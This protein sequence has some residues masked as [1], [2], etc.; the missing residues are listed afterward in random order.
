MTP[1][2][3]GLPSNYRFADLTLDVARRCVTRQDRTIELKA[4]DFDLLRF[5][6]EQAPNVVNPDVLAEKVWGRHFV[7]PENVAQR[8]MLLRQSLSD[9]ANKPRY[10]ETVRNKGYRLIPV[11]ELAPAETRRATPWPRRLVTAAAALL[12]AVAAGY[13]LV[14][15]MER[16]PPLPKSVAVL[17]FE[18]WSPD[19]AQAYFAIGMQEAIVSQ[20]LKING[21]R[22][23]RVQ[24]ADPE[25]LRRLNVEAA[26]GGSVSYADGRVRVSPHLA[27][28]ATDES[29]WS[30]SYERAEGGIFAIQSSIALDVARALRVELSASERQR[31]EHTP[32][33]DPRARDL[34]LRARAR[35]ERTAREEVLRAIDE[36]EEALAIEPAFAEAWVVDAKFRN[37]AQFFDPEH[38][39]EHRARGEQAARR[40]VDLDAESGAAHGALGLALSLMKDWRGSEAAYRRARSLNVSSDV[41]A[42][43]MLQLDVGNFAFARELFEEARALQP[44]NPTL[45]RFLMFANAALGDWATATE[46][47]E[48]GMD[49]FE[50]WNEGPNNWMH[51]LIGRRDLAA[52]RALPVDDPF[53][54]AMLASL[55]DPDNALAQ[56]REAYA[57]AGAVDPNQLSNIGIWAAHFGDVI[58]AFDAMR[59]AI[60]EQGGQ[61]VYVWMPQLASMRRLP[62][63]KAYLREIGMVD[64]WNEY[65]WPDIC[66][67]RG[68]DDFECD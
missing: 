59:A 53:N 5:L 14:G 19:P 12:L 67:E 28:T 32:A 26:L 48:S 55:D 56:I 20:L 51:W 38:A 3:D 68:E 15:A 35:D 52:A 46:Q 63:F 58:L 30:D 9:D 40:A 47:Y 4:L 7:S 2:A 22:V 43:P 41:S 65:G 29:L 18:N 27:R 25:I 21:L 31:I 13:W 57:V 62:E 50:P 37:V 1:P 16:P 36:I 17:P 11:V 60:D 44:Q 23:F 42:Y 66:R 33:V 24:S 54:A 6:V 8:V 34:F 49:L 64:Y 39:A 10:I 61:M 45:H